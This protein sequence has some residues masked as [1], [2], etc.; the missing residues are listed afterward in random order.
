[1]LFIL[2]VFILFFCGKEKYAKESRPKKKLRFFPVG[3]TMG[4]SATA[5]PS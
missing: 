2:R 3:A 1:M 4:D 5:L